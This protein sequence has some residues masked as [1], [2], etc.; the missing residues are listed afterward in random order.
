LR[1]RIISYI[2]INRLFSQHQMSW[3]C[4]FKGERHQEC[5]HSFSQLGSDVS[6]TDNIPWQNER[7]IA[8]AGIAQL[9]FGA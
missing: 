7:P 5:H 1:A 2:A 3:C 8:G 4:I 9:C 6:R